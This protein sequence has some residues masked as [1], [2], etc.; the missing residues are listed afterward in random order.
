MYRKRIV[1]KLDDLASEFL[2]SWKRVCAVVEENGGRADLGINAGACDEEVFDWVRSLDPKRF[3]VWNHTWDHGRSG[4]NHYGHPYDAQCENMDRHQRLVSEKLGMTMRAFG[5]GG[6]KLTPESDWIGDH[7]EV[8]YCVVRNHPDMWV[9]YHA[10]EVIVDRGRGNINSDGILTPGGFTAIE[11]P[12]G[13]TRPRDHGKRYPV[14]WVAKLY[15]DKD[16]NRP[17]AVGNAGE[18]IWRM[19]HPSRPAE[20]VARMASNVLGFHPW[21]WMEED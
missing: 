3:E 13:V 12:P 11:H 4:P 7:D 10:E 20:E 2:P 5:C 16:P 6:I 21:N 15:P 19:Q 1:L 9:Y 8:T 18:L 17:P 14:E